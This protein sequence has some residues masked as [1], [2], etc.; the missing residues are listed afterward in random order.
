T[1]QPQWALLL[2]VDFGGSGGWGSGQARERTAAGGAGIET[3]RRFRSL[4]EREPRPIATIPDWTSSRMPKGSTSRMNDASLSALPVI[5]IVT[6][7]VAT[8]TTRALNSAT[9]SRTCPRDSASALTLTSSSSRVTEAGPSSSTI[10]MTSTSLL[11]CLVT[12][13]SGDSSTLTTIV[14]RETSWCSVGPTASESM[15]NPRRLN[16]PAI[17]A[18]TPGLYS[19]STDR[20]CLLIDVLAS[21]RA[22]MRLPCTV[23]NDGLASLAH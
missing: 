20:V 21:L 1:S 11:S 2:V 12:C 14:I 3:G 23:L 4:I 13:S 17:R 15:L 8:S 16:R 18:R 10:L 22:P 9:A 5:S 19:T 7:S 6:A